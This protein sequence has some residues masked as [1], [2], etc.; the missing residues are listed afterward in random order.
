MAQISAIKIQNLLNNPEEEE[1]EAPAV[2]VQKNKNAKQEA[3]EKKELAK[4]KKEEERVAAKKKKEAEREAAKKKKQEE[5]NA[6]KRR[7]E[8]EKEAAAARKI[9][10]DKELQQLYRDN[11]RK[12][13]D[14]KYRLSEQKKS[15]A[16]SNNL[17]KKLQE[18]KE[19]W[20]QECASLKADMETSDSDSD[21]DSDSETDTDD[22]TDQHLPTQQPPGRYRPRQRNNVANEDDED[23]E[24]DNEETE[25]E[26]DD[27]DEDEEDESDHQQQSKK[28]GK[29]KM[30]RERSPAGRSS[31]IIKI[32]A[33]QN[34]GK[35]RQPETQ[36][37]L[38]KRRRKAPP[39]QSTNHSEFYLGPLS[40]DDMFSPSVILSD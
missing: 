30:Q 5:R 22:E 12:L 34:R 13:K 37:S 24:D 1:I 27:N 40:D 33:S 14:P 20:R 9:S 39:S 32:N 6:A 15:K 17:K 28:K 36:E 19:K 29:K 4:K 2:S 3:K 10:D 8:E 16:N 21:T 18:A 35:K 7:K 26:D 23:H 38:P 25:E 31:Q 11:L